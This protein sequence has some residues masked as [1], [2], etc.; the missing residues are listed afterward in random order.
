MN[1]R[2]TTATLAALVLASTTLVTAQILPRMGVS[3]G[4]M[5]L[6]VRS[7]I[8]D[9]A[10]SMNDNVFAG[11]AWYSHG[12]LVVDGSYTEGRLNSSTGVT[13]D[14]VE[15]RAFAGVRVFRM[16]SIKAGPQIL[17]FSLPS[18]TRRR[19]YWETR[20]RFET[21]ITNIIGAF[22][23]GWTAMAAQ[24][25]VGEHVDRA[26]GAEA[27]LIAHLARWPIWGKLGYRTERTTFDQGLRTE[28]L[29]GI[30]LSIGVGSSR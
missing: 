5:A 15:A 1:V 24:S 20:A 23:E 13:R 16:L 29:D 25:N 14:F 26:N 7:D 6:T 2:V 21:P 19:I 17:A 11:D 4:G 3:A 18:G 12:L 28:T 22:A 8:A 30:T 27:A 10:E 9:G